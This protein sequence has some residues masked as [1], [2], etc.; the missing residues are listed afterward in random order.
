MPGTDNE[1]IIS[2]KPPVNLSPTRLKS[3]PGRRDTR[4]PARKLLQKLPVR[5]T[6][7]Y[8][9]S[10]LIKILLTLFETQGLVNLKEELLA[11]TP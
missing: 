8:W 5:F 3:S 10:V 6:I 1:I 2:A 7:Q 11:A 4:G 9:N